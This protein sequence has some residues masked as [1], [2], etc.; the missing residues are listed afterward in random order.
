VFT[1][2]D[3]GS[4]TFAVTLSATGKQTIKVTDTLGITGSAVTTV[5]PPAV[6]THFVIITPTSVTAGVPVNVTVQALDASNRIVTGYTGTVHF[7]SSDGNALLPSDSAFTAANNGSQ[8]FQVAFSMSGQQ[9]LTVTSVTGSAITGTATVRVGSNMGYGGWNWY[10]N[11][12]YMN[13][14]WGVGYP[15]STNWVGPWTYFV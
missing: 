11:G 2:T 7:T 15:W 4:H 6:A 5:C 12:S 1:P 8:Q 14:Y 13:P 9:T 3:A 10:S